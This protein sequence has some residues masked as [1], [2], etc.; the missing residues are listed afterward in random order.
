LRRTGLGHLL[1]NN[2]TELIST[3]VALA[4]E[5]ESMPRGEAEQLQRD[6][7]ASA[8]RAAKEEKAGHE[9]SRFLL[10]AHAFAVRSQSDALASSMWCKKNSSKEG[11]TEPVAS[12]DGDS[13]DSTVPRHCA[14]PQSL[15]QHRL[16]SSSHTALQGPPLKMP[17]VLVRRAHK[18][19]STTHCLSCE[20]FASD[21]RCSEEATGSTLPRLL[22]GAM[23]EASCTQLLPNFSVFS[24]SSHSVHTQG[25]PIELSLSVSNFCI[26]PEMHGVMCLMLDNSDPS[27]WMSEKGPGISPPGSISDAGVSNCSKYHFSD[28]SKGAMEHSVL[29]VTGQ[30]QSA[31]AG[32][33][34]LYFRLITPAGVIVGALDVPFTITAAAAV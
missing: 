22:R 13:L 24:P 19:R 28:P 9:W 16:S 34:W 7:A 4:Q 32:E 25:A 23:T 10:R 2:E 26:G 20:A 29:N 21:P 12:P 18:G 27:C 6:I 30:I 31:S 1:V 17:R 8:S 14:L 5:V 33:H 15:L 11:T 3:A